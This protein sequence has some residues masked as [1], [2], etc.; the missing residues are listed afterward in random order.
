[1]GNRANLY[2]DMGNTRAALA[3]YNR[4]IALNPEHHLAYAGRSELRLCGGDYARAA[5]DASTVIGLQPD[6]HAGYALRALANFRRGQREPALIDDARAI[7]LDT[8]WQT[9]INTAVYLTICRTMNSRRC[10]TSS[11]FW[12]RGNATFRIRRA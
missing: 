7:Q 4:V 9:P 12:N 3:D 10:A 6:F 11:R 1:V 8:A 5:L 2:A